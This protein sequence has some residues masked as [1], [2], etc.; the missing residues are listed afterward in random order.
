[1]ITFE[2]V[3]KRYQGGAIALR[4]I[5]FHLDAGEMVFL[6][7]HSGA[8]KSTL[9]RLTLMLEQ[10]TRGQVLVRRQKPQQNILPAGTPGTTRHRD[11]IPGLQAAQRQNR[12]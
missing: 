5:S 4:D 9:L 7:G 2:R 10:A 1:M 6:T 3:T 12:F 11:D 8:G